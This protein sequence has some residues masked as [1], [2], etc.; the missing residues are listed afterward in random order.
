MIAT[1]FFLFFAIFW[2][3][4]I[5]CALSSKKDN[6]A[7][8]HLRAAASRA[9]DKN[10]EAQAAEIKAAQKFYSVEDACLEGNADV[11][12]QKEWSSTGEEWAIKRRADAEKNEAERKALVEERKATHKAFYHLQV[13]PILKETAEMV[14]SLL[15]ELKEEEE[16]QLSGAKPIQ[17]SKPKTKATPK[18][19]PKKKITEEPEGS[20]NPKKMTTNS[21]GFERSADV[22]SWV[23]ESAF[24]ICESCDDPAPFMT[25]GQDYLEVHHVRPL[26]SGGSDTIQNAVAI[27]PN[28]HRAFHHSDDK[29]AMK[30]R[31]YKRVSRLVRE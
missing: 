31:L 7:L 9:Q 18:P 1:I 14:E 13:E 3:A 5:V 17:K 4:V 12:V 21:T 19:R 26:G 29:E 10:P 25:K 16:A 2:I 23:L 6:K 15:D 22:K 8:G 24:G 20:S 28:C 27:C 30:D 11:S